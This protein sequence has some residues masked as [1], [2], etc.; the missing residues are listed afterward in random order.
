MAITLV[1]SA[2]KDIAGVNNTTLAFPSPLT[3]GNLLVVSNVHYQAAGGTTITTPTDTL[4]HTYLPVSAQQNTTDTFVHLRSFYVANCSP[5]A[6]TVTVDISGAANGEIT[7]II[8]EWGGVVTASPLSGTPTSPGPVGTATPT[9]GNITP[10]DDNCVLI[11]VLNAGGIPVT[12]TPDAGWTTVQEYEGT[13]NTVTLSVVYKL[14]A[15]QATDA[16]GWTISSAQNCLAHIMAFKP[17]VVASGILYGG[18]GMQG[19]GR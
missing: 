11:G 9:T 2:K 5:G 16:A 8:S 17:V 13:N 18:L 19:Y 14:Q 3:A 4:A 1:Q 7:V 10:V 12:I 6:D 15:S